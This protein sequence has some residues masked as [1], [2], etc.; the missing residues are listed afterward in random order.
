MKESTSSLLVDNCDQ[1]IFYED[2]V[3]SSG[4]PSFEGKVPKNKQECYKLL[5]ENIDA[6]QRDTDG[7]ILAS[8]LKDTIRRK[9]PEFSER[10]YGYRSFTALLNEAAGL[11]L[12]E[13]HQDPKSGTAVVDGFCD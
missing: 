13:I 1:Y 12:I 7:A 5:L 2:I 8:L 9:R 4:V 3:S 10:S 11:K 6:L